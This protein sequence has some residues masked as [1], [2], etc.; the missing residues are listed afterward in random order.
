MK[1]KSYLYRAIILVGLLV[2]L[3]DMHAFAAVGSDLGFDIGG[4]DKTSS[5]PTLTNLFHTVA[6]FA[7]QYVA[8]IIGACLCIYGLFTAAMK[9]KI[10]G[11]FAIGFGAV[12]LFLPTILQQFINF[13]NNGG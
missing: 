3:K 10:A 4:T 1:D 11:V 12:L 6:V 2:L 5:F 7:V 8:R 9:D 13:G